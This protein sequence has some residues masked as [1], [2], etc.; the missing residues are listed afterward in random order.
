MGNIIV[1]PTCREAVRQI[2]RQKCRMA[3]G[4]ILLLAAALF[5]RRMLAGA[6]LPDGALLEELAQTVQGREETVEEAVAAFCREI[7]IN[8]GA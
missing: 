7:F 1:Y 2:R 5:A 8:G 4:F 3:A 6:F